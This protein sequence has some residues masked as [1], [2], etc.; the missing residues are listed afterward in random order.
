MAGFEQI[1]HLQFHPFTADNLFFVNKGKVTQYER[2][3]QRLT[4]ELKAMRVDEKKKREEIV[5]FN[6][7]PTS[8]YVPF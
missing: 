3:N 4:E 2:D 8:P 1:T 5:L 7:L 6:F